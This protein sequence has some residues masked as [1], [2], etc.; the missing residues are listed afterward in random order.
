MSKSKDTATSQN[1]V[2]FSVKGIQEKKGTEIV[3]I[4]LKNIGNAVASYFVICTGNSDTQ[5]NAIAES[6]EAE[7][8]K[9]CKEDPWHKEGLQNKEWVLLDYV[10]VVIHIFKK[11]V[12]EFYGIEDLWGDAEILEI[13]GAVE[14]KQKVSK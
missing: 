7:V 1:I 2:D 8:Y 5:V 6:I 14:V 4:N 11:E 3:V 12:R 10:D 9:N 13:E